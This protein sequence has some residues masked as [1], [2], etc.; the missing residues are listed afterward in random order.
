MCTLLCA[1]TATSSGC[2]RASTA[3][4]WSASTSGCPRAAPCAPFASALPWIPRSYSVLDT[5]HPNLE[6]EHVTAF[7]FM[8]GMLRVRPCERLNLHPAHGRCGLLALLSSLLPFW[9]CVQ[10]YRVAMMTCGADGTLHSHSQ[11][12]MRRPHRRRPRSRRNPASSPA[13][14]VPS[15]L[16]KACTC[17]HVCRRKWRAVGS[18]SE[19]G[20][21]SCMAGQTFQDHQTGSSDSFVPLHWYAA[22]IMLFY[23]VTQMAAVAVAARP[24]PLR[25]GHLGGAGCSGQR[26]RGG[27]GGRGRGGAAPVDAAQLSGHALC[28]ACRQQHRP[29]SRWEWTLS[30]LFCTHN[31]CSPLRPLCDGEPFLPS[32]S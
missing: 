28:P 18:R 16:E 17:I 12:R 21:L 1:G 15:D 22:V 20:R 3:S 9:R 26:R 24:P 5:P 31:K 11:T 4:T 6:A 27:G 32:G 25:R 30:Q 19:S 13:G 23:S 10:R 29:G 7:V 8:Y 14:S 2:C